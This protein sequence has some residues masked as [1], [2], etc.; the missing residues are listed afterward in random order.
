MET[1]TA[2]DLLGH[3][4][5]RAIVATLHNTSPLSWSELV[6]QVA[7]RVDDE[8]G[9]HFVDEETRRRLRIGLYHTHLPKLAEAGAVEYD[10]QTITSTPKLESL[11]EYLNHHWDV[12][13]TSDSLSEQ[14]AGFYA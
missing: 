10:D 9:V 6:D 8:P 3:E 13:V 2:L 12:A 11:V 1:Q 14:I 4:H 7:A 5:R